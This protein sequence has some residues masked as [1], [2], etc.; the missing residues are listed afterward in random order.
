MELLELLIAYRQKKMKT[1]GKHIWEELDNKLP[2]FIG[3]KSQDENRNP[4]LFSLLVKLSIKQRRALAAYLEAQIK[5]EENNF[6]ELATATIEEA[7]RIHLAKY[8]E[9]FEELQSFAPIEEMDLLWEKM[10]IYV[11]PSYRLQKGEE[12]QK[13]LEEQI[14]GYPEHERTGKVGKFYFWLTE[15]QRYAYS[16]YKKIK[17]LGSNA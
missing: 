1:A 5:Y 17:S 8:N 15:I 12:V 10:L 3:E 14:S 16:Y 13:W 6:E 11:F 4:R 7:E 9:V 2:K